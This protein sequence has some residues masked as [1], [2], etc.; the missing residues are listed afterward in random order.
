M[1]LRGGRAQ[2]VGG[3]QQPIVHSGR[4]DCIMGDMTGMDIFVPEYTEIINWLVPA[5]KCGWMYEGKIC[6][7]Y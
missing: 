4:R 7:P 3:H 5:F 2:H 1:D 6:Y